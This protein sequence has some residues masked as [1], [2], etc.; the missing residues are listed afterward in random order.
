MKREMACQ[1]I[2]ARFFNNPIRDEARNFAVILFCADSEFLAGKF[3]HNH[4]R[5][6]GSAADQVVM[7][8]YEEFLSDIAQSAKATAF[9][10]LK[11]RYGR[12]QLT[13]PRGCVTDNPAETL[14]ELYELLVAPEKTVGVVAEVTEN[15]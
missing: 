2:V 5:I 13:E 9:F 10:S 1:Y 8:A 3:E 15:A 6:G 11:V 7:R 12:I 4:D 14:A